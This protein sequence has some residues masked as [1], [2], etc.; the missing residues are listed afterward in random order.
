MINENI[1]TTHI[2]YLFNLFHFVVSEME[3][4]SEDSDSI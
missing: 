3:E 1:H 2:Q 4:Q